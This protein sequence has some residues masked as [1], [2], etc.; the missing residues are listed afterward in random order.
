MGTLIS[1]VPVRRSKLDE[2]LTSPS[3]PYSVLHLPLLQNQGRATVDLL[4]SYSSFARFVAYAFGTQISPFSTGS[5][6]FWRRPNH[7]RRRR[8]A[9]GALPSTIVQP[10]GKLRTTGQLGYVQVQHTFL[11]IIV[12]TTQSSKH[13]HSTN[14]VGT[15]LPVSVHS[16]AFTGYSHEHTPHTINSGSETGLTHRSA[17]TSVAS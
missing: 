3:V 9:F 7:E 11:V 1:F 5:P 17:H 14:N 15:S 10:F 16:A 4:G 6:V 2:E 12:T 8:T 13:I